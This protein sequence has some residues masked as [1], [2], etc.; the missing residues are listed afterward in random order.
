MDLEDAD[1]WVRNLGDEIFATL[2]NLSGSTER[3]VWRRQIEKSKVRNQQVADPQFVMPND[4]S[5]SLA[6]AA[7]LEISATLLTSDYWS[8]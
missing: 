7:T 1:I 6:G 5:W 2:L 3:L 8:D 4:R